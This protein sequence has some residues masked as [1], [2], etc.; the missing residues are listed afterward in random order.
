MVSH[1]RLSAVGISTFPLAFSRPILPTP[2]ARIYAPTRA[3]RRSASRPISL[4]RI[5][6][7]SAPASQPT[8]FGPSPT[9]IYALAITC[10]TMVYFGRRVILFIQ[11]DTSYKLL[12][13]RRHAHAR[14]RADA[15]RRPVSP[16][17]ILTRRA[18]RR[19]RRLPI[20]ADA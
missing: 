17:R 8:G 11:H 4:A 1:L 16:M 5:T 19:I 10:S 12:I 6:P 9:R 7:S 13:R 14:A 18:Y 15:A 20:L 2:L 3:P